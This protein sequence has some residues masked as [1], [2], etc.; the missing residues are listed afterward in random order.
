MQQD[1][2]TLQ[3]SYKKN[4]KIEL[5]AQGLSSP[6]SMAFIDDNNI[7]VLEKNSGLVRL[8]SG[9]VLQNKPV[10]KLPID[11][12]AERGLL[13]IAVLHTNNINNNT[14]VFLYFTESNNMSS[15]NIPNDAQLRNRT[16]K[17][18]WSGQTL[19][20]P[21]LVLDLPAIPGPYHNG[22]KLIVGP[23]HHLYIVI[24]D[25]AGP[26]T[27]AQNN[28]TGPPIDGTGGILRVT[29][30]GKAVSDPPLGNKSPLNLYYAYGIR[31][32][33][34]I[35]FDPLNGKLWDT[36]NGEDKY[37]EINVVKPGF[38]SGWSKIIGPLSRNSDSDLINGELVNLPGSYYS[39][40][41]FSWYHSIGVTDIEFLK[42][43]KLG[44]KYKN[45]LFVGDINNGNLYY[46]QLNDTREGLKFNSSE[47]KDLVAD[48]N[49]ELSEITFASGFKGITDIETGPDGYLYILSYLDGKLYRIVP[50]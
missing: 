38:N 17:Y 5:V 42:S 31:N 14:N 2:P 26:K 41:V 48:N 7:L 29:Q 8:I 1:G 37:D 16:Y 33:F 23:D 46:F 30:A 18:E 15:K 13:G 19:V 4:L 35:T 9:G 11:N 10:L 36:E 3:G 47:L 6:T 20:N 43:L 49:N 32:S 44:E 21:S 45:N 40:P 24:G 25:L 12:K 50:S 39:D 22:G 27:Q 34:G 28:K